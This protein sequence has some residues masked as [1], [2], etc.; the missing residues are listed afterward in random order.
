MSEASRF[1]RI[2][3]L[4]HAAQALAPTDRA[5]FLAEACG[6]DAS[7]RSEVESLL[8]ADPGRAGGF[9]S[10]LTATFA[11]RPEFLREGEVV[12]P[13]RVGE[14]IGEGGMGEIYR[15]EQLRPL[16][17]EVALKVVKAG[18]D[19]RQILRRFENERQALALMSHPGI[20][21]VFDAGATPAGRLFFAMELVGGEPIT[22]FCD[23]RRMPLGERLELFQRVCDAV[24]HAHQK[25][26]IHRDLKPSN[27]LVEEQD[28]RARPK[29]I[30]FGIAKA[31]APDPAGRRATTR[32][33][34]PVG[35][36]EYMS[37]EQAGP[38]TAIDTR[39]DVYSLG[40]VLYELLAGEHPFDV[41]RLRR[42]NPLEFSTYLRNTEA[43]RLSERAARSADAAAARRCDPT[44]LRRD[45]TG[46]LDWIVGKALEK[47]PERRYAS[48]SELAAD[49]ARQLHHEPVLA[50]S[51]SRAYRA[52]KFVRR[53][54][55][56]VATAAAVF[57][58]LIGAIGGI[59]AA[60]VRAR[61]AEADALRQAT[62]ANEVTGFLAGLFAVED[63]Y[64]AEPGERTVRAVVSQAAERL[65]A[66]GVEDPEVFGRLASS[67]ASVM[68]NQGLREEALELT[69][70]AI[71]RLRDAAAA[72]G[73]SYLDLL[74]EQSRAESMLGRYDDARRTSSELVAL[75]PEVL[76]PDSPR[77]GVYLKR[78]GDAEALP[79]GTHEE[80]VL[81]HRRAMAAMR[82]APEASPEDLGSVLHALARSTNKA[83]ECAELAN[84]ELE[85]WREHL[86]A[87]HPRVA[88]ARQVLGRCA[89]LVGDAEEAER[90]LS[91]AVDLM[92]TALEPGH[93]FT[94]QSTF[95]L[96][97]A[98]YALGN[99]E[100]AKRIVEAA[101]I[102][103]REVNQQSTIATLLNMSFAY[104]PGTAEFEG[105]RQDLEDAVGIFL[106]LYDGDSE[107]SLMARHTLADGYA[108]SGMLGEARDRYLAVLRTRVKLGLPH[109]FFHALVLENLA[110]TERR[111]GLFAE[112]ERHIDEALE[113]YPSISWDPRYHARAWLSKATLLLAS[114]KPAE[115]EMAFA[116][117]TEIYAACR[118]PRNF[119]DLRYEAAWRAVRGER[120]RAREL[121]IDLYR[122]GV[123]PDFLA[124][125]PELVALFGE[126][127]LRDLAGAAAG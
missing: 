60:L 72:E 81:W 59:S 71:G 103:A 9:G 15:A 57:I 87:G 28:G 38:A 10:T 14:L 117:A 19:T 34:Q 13:Y 100:E 46:D 4:F 26:I 56:P 91:E 120:N 39:T 48:A 61:H 98:H 64:S 49:I 108:D 97:D 18:M 37:P 107:W 67:L 84:E 51:P 73:P 6:A 36:P 62:V 102:E 76:A 123:H 116:R 119:L 12:G 7:L 95:L 90:Q 33:G 83:A 40:L 86:G 115:S 31:V 27:I 24:Q 75:A 121:L 55:W 17:R 124:N 94:F 113:L 1:K 79:G 112:A 16:R 54:R 45:L 35:T 70:S 65:E 68:L 23:A 44:T 106:G 43:E 88:E 5:A 127:G 50:G 29:I 80:Q 53:H 125:E 47:E 63:P 110:T 25:G 8:A 118:G 105:S 20:A 82:V 85:I 126:D 104:L 111:L 22:E 11:A 32:I 89:R 66:G 114:G 69:V 78:R 3:E 99:F 101:L 42:M 96:L 52:R 41:E 109:N 77:L 93:P 74:Y 21:R 92:R 122:M 58:V 30:D 2:E